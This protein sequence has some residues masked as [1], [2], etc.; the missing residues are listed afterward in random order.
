MC[1][2]EH[3]SGG[4][5]DRRVKGD[6]SWVNFNPYSVSPLEPLGQGRRQGIM[7]YAGPA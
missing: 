7:E 3:V 2:V 6:G 5:A 4:G 1:G